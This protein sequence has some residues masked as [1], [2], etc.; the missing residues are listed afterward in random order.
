MNLLLFKLELR[1]ANGEESTQEER[2]TSTKSTQRLRISDCSDFAAQN[3]NLDHLTSDIS[4][5]SDLLKSTVRSIRWTHGID[6]R[7]FREMAIPLSSVW[8][9]ALG[10]RSLTLHELHS[11]PTVLLRILCSSTHRQSS[12]FLTQI[13][14]LTGH[15]KQ[16]ITPSD[17]ESGSLSKCCS[18]VTCASN[19]SPSTWQIVFRTLLVLFAILFPFYVYYSVYVH[20]F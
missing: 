5:W 10:H 15:F 6:H 18:T 12:F 4:E 7:L 17:V 14:S 16:L 8:H 19:M 1:S 2:R 13:E 3:S 20:D 11:D 9:Q